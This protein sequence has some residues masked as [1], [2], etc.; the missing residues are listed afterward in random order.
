MVGI[1][2]YGAYF[3]R[4]RL[5]RMAIVQNVGWFAPGLMMAAGGE[6]GMCNWD[7]DTM[8]MAVAATRDCLTGR[9]KKSLDAAYLAST[10]LPFRDRQNAGI[11]AAA[12]NL[13]E[14]G[15]V[16]AD[17]AASTKSGT[18]AVLA[19]IAAVKAGEKNNVIVTA[20]DNRPTKAAWFYQL[21]YGDGAASLL[22]GKN[23]VIAEFKGAYSVSCDFV[24]SYR[25]ADTKFDY[26]WEERWIRDEGFTKIIPQ[27]AKGLLDK[28]KLSMDQVSKITY[29]CYLSKG[30]HRSLAKLVGASPD[31]VVDNL[32]DVLGDTGSAHPLVLFISALEEANPGDKIIMMSFGQGCDALLFEVTD[33]IKNLPARNGVKGAL[34]YRKEETNYGKLLKWQDLLNVE[35]GIRAETRKQTALSALWRNRTMVLGL[36]GGKCTACGTPQFPKARMCVNPSC[37]AVD[38]QEDYEFAD[39]SGT[40]KSYTGDMLVVS[41]EPP[42][43]YGLVQ[44]D[45]GGRALVDFTDCELDDVKVGQRA[46][47]AFRIKYYDQDRDFHGYFWKAIPQG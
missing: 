21:W 31:K 29:P 25:G 9:D 43:I 12:A 42:A 20:A 27:A 33:C 13:P 16:T 30:I 22:L 46:K 35:M 26:G 24:Q 32:H 23:D 44:F 11:M 37:N 2:A 8:T 7:E 28:C 3:P 5:S 36:V 41:V 18:T 45:G 40:I 17:F 4:R 15:L 6:R 39:I 1:T 19:A 34:A 38:K 10:T 47:M 14:E